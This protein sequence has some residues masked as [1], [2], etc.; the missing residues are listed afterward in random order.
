[1]EDQ[2]PKVSIIILNWNGWKD[3]IEC[4]ESLYQINYPNY[5]VLV[6]DNHSEDDSIEKIK[7][8]CT[9][10]LKVESKFFE[11]KMENKPIQ[12]FEYFEDKIEDSKMND[13]FKA[14][15][16]LILIKNNKN[17]GFA[18]GNNIGIRFMLKNLDSDYTLLLNNDTTVSNLFL[19][20]LV[21]AAENSSVGIVGPTIY[22]YHHP[23][24][25]QSAGAYFSWKKGQG[26]LLRA[27]EIDDHEHLDVLQVDYVS[28]CCLLSK[29]D[30]FLKCGLLDSE[31][32]AYWEEVD[33][34]MR[35]KK[36]GFNVIYTP[37]SRVWHKVSSTSQKIKGLYG[38]Y[39]SRNMFWFMHKNASKVQFCSFL[40]YFTGF[41]FWFMSSLFLL[42]ER[43]LPGFKNFLKGIKDGLSH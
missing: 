9:G 20:E 35:A 12:I 11:Y 28:G 14:N 30:V 23:N 42:Y 40:I 18:E 38:Y 25:I 16:K 41:N 7:Q 29:K 1:M 34:C 26:S 17:Y 24:K 15:K 22:Y 4:L 13:E 6:V 31:Y 27:N 39:I 3:T 33:F 36:A 2:R 8:Y 37:K 43:D 19:D 21:E 32:F 5:D 10:K